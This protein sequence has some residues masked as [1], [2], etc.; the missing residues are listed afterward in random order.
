[1]F[2]FMVKGWERGLEKLAYKTHTK[3]FGIPYE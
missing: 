2:T 1:M 3:P